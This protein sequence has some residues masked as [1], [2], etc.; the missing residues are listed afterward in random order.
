MPGKL[1]KWTTTNNLEIFQI[2]NGRSNVYFVWNGSTGLMVDTGKKFS[3]RKLNRNLQ[4]LKNEGKTIDFLA[5]THTHYDHC[6]NAAKIQAQENCKILVS[7]KEAEFCKNGFT[8]LPLGTYGFSRIIVGLGKRLKLK[9]FSYETFKPDILIENELELQE[10]G[11]L[12]RI[13]S[14]PG[15][16]AGSLSILIDNE[17]ALVG[18]TLFGIFKNSVFPPF[19]ND[20]QELIKSWEKLLNTRCRFFLPGHG[21]KISQKLLKKNGKNTLRNQ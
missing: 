2:L 12:V 11:G 7:K 4:Q 13:I 8:P 6:Q 10:F 19:A 16:T 3:A 18:D 21:R 17:I 15:H 9:R 1:K 20:V 5:L 14:T